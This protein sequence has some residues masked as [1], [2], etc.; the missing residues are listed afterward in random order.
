MTAASNLSAIVP[1]LW[2]A[3]YYD[4]LLADLVFNSLI[5]TDYEGEIRDLGDTVNI[6]T[7]PEFDDGEELAEDGVSD[8]AAVTVS[9]QQL[10]INKRVVKDFIITKLATLQ[11]LP[12]MDKLRE[13]AVYSIL[14]KIQATIIASIVPSAA[15]PD[16]AI[17][18]DSGTTLALA[19]L[20]EAKELLDEANVPEEDR[21]MVLGSAQTNDIFNITGF[22]S[23]D[24]LLAG[25]PL[26]TGKIPAA[27]LGFMPHFTTVAG[28]TAYL[29]HRTFMTIASQ[30]GMD[31]R[32]YD[33]GV[34]GKRAT[35]VNLDTLYG[36][37]QLD[38]ERVVTIGYVVRR[39]RGRLSGGSGVADETARRA[40]Y[41]KALSNEVPIQEIEK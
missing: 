34:G 36:L 8:A 7:F 20:L 41:S 14:K 30:Q 33:L 28:N 31:V 15:A 18:Y 13:L 11:S 38:N 27:L 21:H 10:V 5:S 29:F 25:G 40:P 1:E 26:Q 37:K 19:D 3:R 17:A 23:S 39:L 32:E 35:R 4:V 22:T 6:S 9:G 16:H 24:F 12:A 2:S